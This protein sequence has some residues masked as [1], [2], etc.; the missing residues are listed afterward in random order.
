MTSVTDS[1]F[2]PIAVGV[3]CVRS[4]RTRD[5]ILERSTIANRLSGDKGESESAWAAELGVFVKFAVPFRA[6]GC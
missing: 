2:V 3:A 1:P 5:R 6:H 4:D